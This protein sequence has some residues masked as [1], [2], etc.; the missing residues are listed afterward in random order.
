MWKDSVWLC[1][2]VVLYLPDVERIK[3]WCQ[4]TA[5]SRRMGQE[6]KQGKMVPEQV[7]MVRIEMA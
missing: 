2:Y 1:W 6:M 7:V 5:I 4:T 3:L